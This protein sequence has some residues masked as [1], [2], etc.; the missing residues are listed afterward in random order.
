MVAMVL[1][2]PNEMLSIMN[3][4]DQFHLM[5]KVWISPELDKFVGPLMLTWLK[6]I[7]LSH[8][9]CCRYKLPLNYD[10]HDTMV[11]RFNKGSY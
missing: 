7:A 4:M 6:V 8:Q 10:Q 1:I 5:Q 2:F 11:D 9:Q 3:R